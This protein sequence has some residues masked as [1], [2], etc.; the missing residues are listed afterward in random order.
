MNGNQQIIPSAW[1]EE[2]TR[3]DT[4]TDPTANY[5]YNWWVDQDRQA[6]YAEGDK[7]QFIYVYPK[8]DLVLARFG[9][10]CGGTGFIDLL[11]NIAQ[12]LETQLEDK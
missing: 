11:G 3:V 7:C 2:A 5:Q 1:V 4:T 8:A 6:F 9:T 10:D 12:W